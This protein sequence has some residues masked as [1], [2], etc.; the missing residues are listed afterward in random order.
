MAAGAGGSCSVKNCFLQRLIPDC[1]RGL[2]I[3][4]AESDRPDA[5]IG[6]ALLFLVAVWWSLRRRLCFDRKTGGQTVVPVGAIRAP[7]VDSGYAPNDWQV[8]P[9]RQSC[10]TRN[11]LCRDWYF[12]VRFPGT[13]AV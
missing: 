13:W 1:P 5:Y 7:T 12:P 4:V 3:H 11:L 8:R 6:L 10:R 2:K 9:D